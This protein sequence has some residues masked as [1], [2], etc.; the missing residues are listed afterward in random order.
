MPIIQTKDL[1]VGMM[2]SE[3]T[4]SKAGQLIVRKDSILS[5]QMISHLKFYSITKVNI[6]EDALSK[7]ILDAI[8]NRN[9][10][11]TTQLERILQSK[12]YKVFKKEYS[13][14]VNMLEN[15]INDILIRNAPVDPTVLVNETVKIFDKSQDY[16]SFFGML[17]SMKQIDDSTFAHSVNVAMIA[18]LIGTWSNFDKE[19]L[20]LLTLAGLLHDIGKCQIPDKILMIPRKLTNEEY[21]FIKL[22][23]QFGYEILKNQDLDMRIKQATLLHHERCDGSGYPFGH[24]IQKLG[25]FECIISIADVYDAMTADRCY[26]SGLCPFEVISFF[27]EEGLQKYH[28]KYIT[29]FLQRIARSYLNSDVLLSNGDIARII[30][31]NERLTRPTVQLHKNKAFLNLEQNPHIYIQEII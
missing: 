4:F 22:H 29:S 12:E 20:D 10:V 1:K 19:T 16:F 17:H 8:E 13:A 31:L 26:R 11:Q 3:N 30:F 18:R 25:D 2:V 9:G 28:P 27:E 14:N 5:R 15:N 23:A 24:D 6:Y 21:Q 7:E